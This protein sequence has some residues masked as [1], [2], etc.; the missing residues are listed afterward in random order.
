V[1]HRERQRGN[2]VGED[3]GRAKLTRHDVDLI[4][5]LYEEGLPL[6]KIA[7]KFEVAKS[8]IHDIVTCRTWSSPPMQYK[9]IEIPFEGSPL[10]R[11]VKEE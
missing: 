4:H 2:R 1:G 10:R 5:D 8:T 11:V 6:T 9:T 3:H 7:E